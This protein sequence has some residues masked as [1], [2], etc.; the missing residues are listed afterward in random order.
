MPR[1]E[2]KEKRV[3]MQQKKATRTA[4]GQKREAEMIESTFSTEFDI[5]T[6]RLRVSLSFRKAV[7]FFNKKND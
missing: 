3:P 1:K 7:K 5:P 2:L 6:K 4:I